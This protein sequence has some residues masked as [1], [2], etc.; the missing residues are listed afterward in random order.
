MNVTEEMVTV[1]MNT[2]LDISPDGVNTAALRAVLEEALATPPQPADGGD[3]VSELVAADRYY[4]DAQFGLA[5]A[6]YNGEP[7]DVWVQDCAKA[8]IRRAAALAKFQPAG[9]ES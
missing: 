7:L 8:D 4:D 2:Y 9:G 1:A 6:K 3:R 5:R